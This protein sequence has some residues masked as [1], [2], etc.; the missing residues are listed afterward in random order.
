MTDA[1]IRKL[2]A[3][4]LRQPAYSADL[5]ARTVAAI[6]A[7][8]NLADILMERDDRI[9]DLEAALEKIVQLEPGTPGLH[10]S[11]GALLQSAVGFA[12]AELSQETLKRLNLRPDRWIATE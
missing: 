1:T 11:F 5:Y 2:L 8:R 3:E 6:A 12:R 10:G 9:A 4:W 7:L